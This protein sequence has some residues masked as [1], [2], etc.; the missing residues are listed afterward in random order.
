MKKLILTFAVAFLGFG[1]IAQTETIA[2]AVAEPSVEV[3]PSIQD[4]KTEITYEK[5]PEAVSTAFKASENASKTVL[6]VYEIKVSETETNYELH[7]GTSDADKVAV[8]YN[9]KGELVK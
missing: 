2:E 5:L 6:K 7:V 9:A 4:I 3:A 1:A 8:T